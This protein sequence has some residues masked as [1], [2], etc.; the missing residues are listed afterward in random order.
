[1]ADSLPLRAELGP[2]ILFVRTGVLV[3]LVFL[4]PDPD[5]DPVPVPVASSNVFCI[6]EGREDFSGLLKPSF[7]L[8][9]LDEFEFEFVCVL[10]FTVSC[11]YSAYVQKL[12]DFL[13][14]FLPNLTLK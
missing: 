7:S 4:V 12:A 9:E 5:P 6:M 10:V 2:W 13:C 8:T 14:Q 1:V 3:K 11:S